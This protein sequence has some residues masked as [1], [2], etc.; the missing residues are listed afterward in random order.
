MYHLLVVSLLIGFIA[1]TRCKL[2]AIIPSLLGSVYVG[3]KYLDKYL[4]MAQSTLNC[5]ISNIMIH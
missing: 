3:L 4:N 2:Q 1:T 5:I